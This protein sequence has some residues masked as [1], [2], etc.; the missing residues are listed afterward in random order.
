M[1]IHHK[2]YI[3][4]TYWKQIICSVDYTLNE[5]FTIVICTKQGDLIEFLIDCK[6]NSVQDTSCVDIDYSNVR[7]IRVF[8]TLHDV[9]KIVYLLHTQSQEL[10]I[11][12]KKNKK[13]KVKEK[14]HKVQRFQISDVNHIGTPHVSIWY[15]NSKEP[16]LV[17]DFS[18]QLVEQNHSDQPSDKLSNALKIQ[19]KMLDVEISERQALLKEKSNMRSSLICSVTQ[20]FQECS[21]KVNKIA[22][23]IYSNKWFIIIE[24]QNDSPIPI[25]DLQLVI[26]V[27]GNKTSYKF[28]VID[29]ETQQIRYLKKLKTKCYGFIMLD[30][31]VFTTD[32][33][34]L[35]GT[36]F[37]HHQAKNGRNNMPDNSVELNETTVKSTVNGNMNPTEGDL[38]IH[39]KCLPIPPI[40]LSLSSFVEDCFQCIETSGSTKLSDIYCIML[41]SYKNSFSISSLTSLNQILSGHLSCSLLCIKEIPASCFFYYGQSG[42]MSGSLFFI[43]C[44]SNTLSVYCRDENQMQIISL[45]LRHFVNKIDEKVTTN[46]SEFQED[47]TH[48]LHL[49]RNEILHDTTYEIRKDFF[50]VKKKH[51][52]EIQKILSK[53]TEAF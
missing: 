17:T 25:V 8:F 14:I 13:L 34:M 2:K 11:V 48:C 1:E 51:I 41:S 10:L 35:H 4:S 16:N 30:I 47:I 29:T 38:F 7:E 36:L 49:L 39:V 18:E 19:L 44:S 50:R 33:L 21:L 32:K 37:Y 46:L 3:P 28:F 6:D 42:F 24:L 31:P 5:Q 53:Y 9:I 43:D 40:E 27:E 45:L 52:F 22:Q 26:S 15:S 23:K 12:E 20:I